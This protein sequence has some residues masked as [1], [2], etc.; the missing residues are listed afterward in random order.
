MQV[1]VNALIA[2]SFAA[3]MASGLSLV[4]GVLG[5]F[6]MSLGQLALFGGYTT[7]WLYSVA[8]FPILLACLS[9]LIVTALVTWIVFEVSVAPFYR[10]HRFLPLVTTIAM[11]VILD[12]AILLLFEENPRSITLPFEKSL[13]LG[14]AIFSSMQIL[15]LFLTLFILGLTVW[16]LV[17]TAF[18]R[19]IRATVQHPEAAESLGIRSFVLHRVIFILSGVL[20]GCAGVYQVLDL[21]LTPVLG[22]TITMKAYAALIA[23]GKESLKGTILCAYGITLLEQLAVSIPFFGSYIPAG[24]QSTVAFVCIILFLLLRP[25]GLFGSSHRL[26]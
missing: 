6:N 11:S 22:F 1:L 12:A 21:N 24:Y 17:G 23:G 15:L 25:R 18:G 16:M 14:G 9:A 7:W 19:K 20:A 8:H 2:G 13:Q 10:R 4:Y 3:L 5:V 26:S